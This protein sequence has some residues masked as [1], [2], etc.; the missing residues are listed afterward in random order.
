MTNNNNRVSKLFQKYLSNKATDAERKEFLDYV[1]DPFY[2]AQIQEL[3]SG[4]FDSQTEITDLN[5]AGRARVLNQIFKN[6]KLSVVAKMPNYRLWPRI[7]AAATILICMGTTFY[8]YRTNQ[9]QADQPIAQHDFKPGGNK[10]ILT[11]GGGKQILLTGARNGQLAMQG[12]TAITKTADGE[13][14]YD[15]KKAGKSEATVYNS[16]STPLGGQ[17]HL[18]LADGTGVWLNA[19]SSIK[20]P[21]AFNGKDR[22]VQITGEAYFEVAH[23][24]AKPFKVIAKGQTVE[25]L[26]THFNVNAYSNEGKTVTTLIEGSVKLSSPRHATLLKPGQQGTIVNGYENIAVK[27]ADTE[28]TMAWKNGLFSFKRAN[29]EMVMR[30]FARWYNV[31]VI[32]EGAVP[33]VAITGKVSRT[34]NANQVLKIV[35]SLGIKFKMEGKKI[36]ILKD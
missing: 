12:N 29:L 4:A 27:D 14:I 36:V 18:V 26:G 21:T 3:L 6:E 30:Q 1:D 17:Y 35:E 23:N 22:Q 11:L 5:D 13:I 33:D 24:A 10:A 15:N 2:Q 28:T 9:Q 31:E 16:M 7:V 8:F 25:V 32:Y 19:A 34:A 20:Y